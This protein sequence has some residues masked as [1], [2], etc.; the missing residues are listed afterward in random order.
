MRNAQSKGRSVRRTDHEPFSCSAKVYSAV[1]RL[2]SNLEFSCSAMTNPDKTVTVCESVWHG[3]TL[4]PRRVCGGA[5]VWN[6][7]SF[8]G[9]PAAPLARVRFPLTSCQ[10]LPGVADAVGADERMHPPADALH[11]PI[12]TR[13]AENPGFVVDNKTA[14]RTPKAVGSLPFVERSGS[15]ERRQLLSPEHAVRQ[16]GEGCPLRKNIK[17]V[18]VKP[19]QAFMTKEHSEAPQADMLLT[20]M[21]S[22]ARRTS[23]GSARRSAAIGAELHQQVSLGMMNITSPTP[24]LLAV[25]ASAESP[26]T[27]REAPTAARSLVR[28]RRDPANVHKYFQSK[29]RDR[30]SPPRTLAGLIDCDRR[31]RE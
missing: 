21:D 28:S 8:G 31:R 1:W 27:V 24:K 19:S 12:P 4:L 30:K 20:A 25:Q 2:G 26:H 11:P 5:N 9:L 22:I 10:Q 23:L 6:A 14:G 29:L 16:H 3:S 18:Y 7:S 15:A 17:A 13:A